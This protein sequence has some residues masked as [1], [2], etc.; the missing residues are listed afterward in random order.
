MIVLKAKVEISAI[1]MINMDA[2]V[3]VFVVKT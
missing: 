1:K 2:K 3:E